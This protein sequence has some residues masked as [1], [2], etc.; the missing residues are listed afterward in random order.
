[1]QTFPLDLQT[2]IQTLQELQ[3][4]G[5]LSTTTEKLPNISGRW[6]IRLSVVAGKMTA[7]DI[8]NAYMRLP[9]EHIFPL[10]YQM[11]VL[12]WQW[13][14]TSQFEIQHSSTQ[15]PVQ[16]HV[17]LSSIPRRLLSELTPQTLQ[18]WSR[19]KLWVFQLVDG[20]RSV[21]DIVVLLSRNEP[22]RVLTIISELCD[23]GTVTVAPATL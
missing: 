16:E 12:E 15:Q 7:C 4:S 8:R 2:I 9:G 19:M 6:S 21:E 18:S 20:E 22:Q 5:I 13:T 17:P 10:L 1:M 23:E 14:T 3:V 11:G